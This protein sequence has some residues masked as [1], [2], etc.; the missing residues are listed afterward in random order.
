MYEGTR[1]ER[2]PVRAEPCFMNNTTESQDMQRLEAGAALMHVRGEVIKAL[3]DG[4]GWRELRALLTA[5]QNAR[6]SLAALYPNE[7]RAPT[8]YNGTNER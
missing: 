5:E 1:L 3:R 4:A 2:G 6:Q 7:E 8:R